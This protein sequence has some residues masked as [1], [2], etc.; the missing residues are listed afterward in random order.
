MADAPSFEVISQHRCFGGVVGFYRHDS[1]STA[2]PMR[3]SVFVPPQGGSGKVPVLYYLA[4]LTC[5]EET[6]MIKA[7]AQRVAA[8][9]GFMLVA[10]DT[11]PRGLNLP[12]ESEAWDFG[13]AAGFYVDATQ[14]PWSNNYRMYSYVVK[15]LRA[16]IESR[17]PADA[18]RTGIFGHSMGGH[19]ALTLGLRNP[20]IYRSIS[21]FAPIGSPKQVPWGH[22]AFVGYLGPDT[23]QWSEHDATEL[24]ARVQ[25]A[26]GRP[27]IL[28]DQGLADQFLEKQL[29]PHLLEAAFHKAGYPLTLRRQEGY[30]HSYYFIS[31]FM[32]DHLRHHA[33]ILGSLR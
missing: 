17:F 15:E 19:G 28:I 26:A 14:E 20:Q 22:K 25:D 27:P 5:T 30:D 18:A 24:V 6:F 13:V 23:G 12:G 16:L 29:K 31:T 4:G 8:E 9:L 7:G 11:S 2:S 1:T 33:K 21:A 10:P 3:F 32:E